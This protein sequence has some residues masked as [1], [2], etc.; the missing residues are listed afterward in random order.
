[1]GYSDTLDEV[2]AKLDRAVL[3]PEAKL[4]PDYVTGIP[5]PF[6]KK[7]EAWI[8]RNGFKLR[9]NRLKK[10][11]REIHLLS[12]VAG[13]EGSM[14]RGEVFKAAVLKL[15]ALAGVPPPSF[16]PEAYRRA[17]E[18]ERRRSLLSAL[19]DLCRG[20]LRDPQV[21]RDARDYLT[22]KRGFPEDSLERLPLGLYTHSGEVRARLVGQNYDIEEIEAAGILRS[23]WH[24]RLVGPWRDWRG[25]IETFWARDITGEAE[26]KILYKPGTEVGKL[27]P[28]GLD[29]ALLHGAREDLVLMEGP[30]DALHLHARGRKNVAAL[31]SSHLSGERLALLARAG[32]RKATLLLDND[33]DPE[34]DRWPGLDGA[35]AAVRNWV[36]TP[37]APGVLVVHPRALGEG[38]KDPDEL[39]RTRGVEAYDRIL[40]QRV[41]GL[42]FLAEDLVERHRPPSGAWTDDDLQAV[43]GE[44][45]E[46][47]DQVA[48]PARVLDVEAF[49]WNPLREVL[50][51]DREVV[52]TH[53]ARLQSR[54][55]EA[56]RHEKV[57]RHLDAM[58]ADLNQALDQGD[59]E[60]AKEL[61]WH[62]ADR[63]RVADRALRADPVLTVAE[64]LEAHDAYLERWRGCE[65]MG[66]PQQTLP[67][68]D[69]A[70]LGL[71]GLM[72]L[73]AA[74]NAGKTALAVQ[75][76]VDV[77][78]ANPDA[79]FLFVSLEMRREEILTRIRCKL[80]QMDWKTLV[81]GSQRGGG[82]PDVSYTAAELEHLHVGR[83]HLQALAPRLCILDEKNF[84]QPTAEKVLAELDDLKRRTGCSRAFLLVDYLQ[85]WP[86]PDGV[87]LRSELDE[88]KWRIGQMKTLR[89]QL[90]D[91]AVLVVSELRKPQGSNDPEWKGGSLAHIMGSAR[92]A[93]TPDMVF[94]F[95]RLTEKE[96]RDAARRATACPL[97]PDELRE[98]ESLLDALSEQGISP[99]RLEIAKGRDGVLRRNFDV[100]FWYR[101][102]RFEE[103]LA[104]EG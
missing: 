67:A 43:L 37:N 16:S 97:N 3:F 95:N 61:L 80:S 42:R 78:Q 102:A 21:G 34:S 39:L 11:G 55:R 50:Q 99:M 17:E 22:S 58:R 30:L 93:Y 104:W 23:S 38:T 20:W 75:L 57:R 84:P 86:I 2:W 79:C 6:C 54:L 100:T 94:L 13:L 88:D 56:E 63:L 48:D 96:A 74:P 65:Y 40:S 83:E 90:T 27:T 14:P 46:V 69:K 15:A 44:A 72:L 41:H 62:G 12:H 91:D 81:F 70:T 36:N 60:Q 9:C 49:F 5:C 25:W 29:A 53:L 10:C 87:K 64:E 77:A 73:A 19:D 33:P 76:G 85:V 92:G 32:V 45:R 28:Y 1:L 31:G 24:G 71:R 66:L 82:D 47:E 8:R 103:G 59:T 18:A 89:D 101:Q 68:L 35:R 4:T 52:E 98:D 26:R 51:L 7:K